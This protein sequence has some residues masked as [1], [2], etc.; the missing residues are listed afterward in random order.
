VL[1][2]ALPRSVREAD[3]DGDKAPAPDLAAIALGNAGSEALAGG[4]WGATI[5]YGANSEIDPNR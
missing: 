1:A 3:P 4:A 2:P 5:G